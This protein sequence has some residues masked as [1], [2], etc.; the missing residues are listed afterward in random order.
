[1]SQSI[2]EVVMLSSLEI[3]DVIKVFTKED[4]LK[5]ADC[6]A[7]NREIFENNLK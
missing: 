5:I 1:M 7:R 3:K 4:L 2:T 6:Y